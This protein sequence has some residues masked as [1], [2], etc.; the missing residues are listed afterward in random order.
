MRKLRI[1]GV[2]GLLALWALSACVPLQRFQESEMQLEEA[3]GTNAKLASANNRLEIK[4]TE[5]NAEIDLLNKRIKELENER[6]SIN[7]GY[8]ELKL[9]YDRLK[10]Q[11]DDLVRNSG[12]LKRGSALENSQLMVELDAAKLDLQQRED[13]LRLLERELNQKEERL[14]KIQVELNASKAQL[15]DREA[16]VQQLEKLINQKDSAA[17]ALRNKVAAA[18]L[19]YADKGL[20][21]KESE[22]GRVQVSVDAALLFASGS[23]TIDQEGRAALVDLAKILEDQDDLQIIV[24]GHTDTDQI[25]GSA[26]FK[27]NWDLSVLRATE[28]VRL[29]VNNSAMKPQSI[30]AAGRGEFLPVDASVKAKNRRIEIYI[31]PNLNE[32]LQLIEKTGKEISLD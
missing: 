11:N 30:T 20:T 17:I 24:E 32:I 27:D 2:L 9:G 12:Q 25:R 21:V 16:R 1:S 14:D 4:N 29:M 28:V 26:R 22:G 13:M 18:L 8:R 19:N 7:L 23:T 5:L 15:Q 10:Q 3:R 6:E 31:A